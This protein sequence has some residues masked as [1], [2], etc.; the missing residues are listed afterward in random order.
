MPTE[1]AAPFGSTPRK[2]FFRSLLPIRFDGY[3][4]TEIAGPFLGGVVFFSFIFLMFQTLRLAEAL[5]EHSVP[6]PILLKMIG[7]MIVS[8]LPLAFP[9]AFLLSTLVAFGRLSSDSELVALTANGMSVYRLALPGFALAAIVAVISLGLNL[10]W[11]PTA[12]MDLKTTLYRLTNTKPIATIKE[13]TFTS[14]F[15]DLLL[16]AEKVDQKKN[17]LEK[18]FIYDERDAK[19]PQTIIARSGAIV[20][21]KIESDLGASIAL[22]LFDGDIHSN[23]IQDGIYQKTSF[24]E[25]QVYLRI[26]PGADTAIGKPIHFPYHILQ[27]ILKT[28]TEP[29]RRREIRTEKMKR[30]MTALAPFF[31]VLIGIGYGTIRGRAVRSGA[32]MTTIFIII[33]FY[34]I[35]T[36]CENWAYAGKLPPSLAMFIPNLFLLILGVRGFRKATW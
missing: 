35:Q 6:G 3:I 22:R 8:F 34:L 26:D 21:I 1:R 33:P 16:Y 27:D 19:N 5:I 30:W 31:F 20:P 4:V 14:G 7:L 13:G 32:A 2:G 15:F 25:Y 29:R 18:V 23:D 11:V 24:R 9:L 10:E 28:E 12:K 36:I 17:E